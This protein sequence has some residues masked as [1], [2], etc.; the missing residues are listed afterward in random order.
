V[1]GGISVRCVGMRVCV[2]AGMWAH[3]CFLGLLLPAL[4]SHRLL[5]IKVIRVIRVIGLLKFVG[6]GLLE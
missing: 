2:C 6:L 4:A 3:G 1:C 5:F